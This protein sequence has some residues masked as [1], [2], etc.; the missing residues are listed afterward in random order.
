M[1]YKS[2][3][4]LFHGCF[5]K[6]WPWGKS[7]DRRW[8]ADHAPLRRLTRHVNNA[9]QNIRQGGETPMDIIIS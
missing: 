3:L 9:A 5:D 1:N 7:R 4:V 6:S 8:A 2:V